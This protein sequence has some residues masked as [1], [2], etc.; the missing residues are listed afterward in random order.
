MSNGP[1]A[2]GFKQKAKREIREFVMIALYLTLLFC[3][4]VTYSMLLLRKYD[5][6]YLTYSFAIVNALIIA[7]IIL[8]GQMMHLGRG[9]E[10]SPLYQTVF[11]KSFIFGLLVFGFHILEEFIK[12][13]IRG[14]PAGTVWHHL[15]LDDLI[16]RSIVI[17]LAFMPLFAFLELRR[18]L[19]EETLHSLFFHPAARNPVIPPGS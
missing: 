18:V 12:R 1:A 3:A 2:T 17:F 5:V 11:Y 7:K 8:I 9:A 4:L 10:G 14:D 19:G 15:R 6:S 13:V 16:G